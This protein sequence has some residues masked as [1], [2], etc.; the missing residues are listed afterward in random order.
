MTTYMK[1]LFT[2]LGL[3][4][5]IALL[6]TGPAAAARQARVAGPQALQLVD[7]AGQVQA[8]WTVAATIQDVLQVGDTLYVACGP[9]GVLIYD[10]ATPDPAAPPA[11][12]L[13]GRIAEGRNVVKL[14]H[15]GRSLLVAV[16]DFSALTFSLD[17]PHKPLPEALLP[18]AGGSLAALV[19]PPPVAAIASRAPLP[20]LASAPDGPRTPTARWARVTKVRGGWIAVETT[21][22]AQIGDRFIVRSQRRVRV[23]DPTASGP[24]YAPSNQAMGMF[25]VTRVV[26]EVA[27]G[28]LP[29]GTVAQVGDLAEPTA[30]PFYAPKVAPRLWYGMGRFYGTL[31]PLIEVGRSS[32]SGSSNSG[33]GL[34]SELTFEYYFR[35]PLKLGVQ[36]A[37]LGLVTGGT[38]GLSTELRALVSFASSYFELGLAPGAEL[39]LLGQPRFTVGYMVRLGSLDGLNL[40]LHNSYVLVTG[41]Y[42]A[43]QLSL[44]SVTGE[45]NIPL[46]SRFNLYLSGGGS[47]YW[48]YGTLGLKYYLRGGGGPGTLIINS[49]LGGAWVSDRCITNTYSTNTQ[50]CNYNS[51]EG[52]GPTLALGLDARF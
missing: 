42:T 23:G 41:A 5:G 27:S 4:C 28:P 11:P 50:Y 43:T 52:V 29:R 7:E 22:P 47:S 45:I 37:P 24:L 13:R 2:V 44:G 33:L 20:D 19:P 40:I 34:L 48:A 16:A 51:T 39:H 12:S 31:Q 32:F 35:I 9:A 6:G 3:F 10:L 17:D 14:A 36:V 38:T 18:P 26:D 8:S 15:N 30:A 21:G 1:K 25:V 46:A 49:G